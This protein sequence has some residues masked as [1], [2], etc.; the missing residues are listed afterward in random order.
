MCERKKNY[1]CHQSFVHLWVSS[2]LHHTLVHKILIHYLD[3]VYFCC[4]Y[5]DEVPDIPERPHEM[6]TRMFTPA[7]G[8]SNTLRDIL[9]DRPAVSKYNNFLKGLQMHNEYV[10]HQQFTKWKGITVEFECFYASLEIH[11]CLV[12]CIFSHY[13]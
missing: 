8:L 9:T 7:G 3:E 6:P 11:N 10:Q 4:L 12:D 2:E 13:Q 1:S 5:L